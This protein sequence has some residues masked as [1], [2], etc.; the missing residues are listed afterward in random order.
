MISMLCGIVILFFVIAFFLG[1]CFS[2]VGLVLKLFYFLCI[3]IPIS[4]FLGSLGIILCC[5]IIGIP[6]GIFCLKHA[7][8]WFFSFL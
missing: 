3:A 4:L 6:L 8:S 2:A 5:T 7:V 1:I